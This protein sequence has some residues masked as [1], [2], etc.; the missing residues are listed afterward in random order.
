[1][2]RVLHDG[3]RVW[4]ERVVHV[5]ERRGQVSNCKL[6]GGLG[7][8]IHQN[9]DAADVIE[10]LRIKQFGVLERVRAPSPVVHKFTG[11]ACTHFA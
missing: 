2:R 4:E 10:Q 9:G 5:I 6:D 11:I 3:G 8:G 7:V 1:M